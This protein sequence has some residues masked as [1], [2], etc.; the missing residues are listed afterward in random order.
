MVQEELPLGSETRQEVL[1]RVRNLLA[2][3]LLGAT[4]DEALLREVVKC[5]FCKT[6]MLASEAREDHNLPSERLAA[7]YR[8]TFHAIRQ[9][10]AGIFGEDEEVLL[11]PDT[12]AVVDLQLERMDLLRS[13]DD[14]LGDV[15]EAFI[16]VALRGQEGQFFTPLAA[17]RLLVDLVEPA[18][19]ERVI[20][21]ACGTGGFLSAV[22]WRWL[23]EGASSGQI[24]ASLYGIDKDSFLVD[25]ARL[26]VALAADTT[27]NI[28]CAD[29]LAWANQ[30]GLPF[31]D[32]LGSFDVVLTNPPFGKHIVAASGQVLG[33]FQLGRKWVRRQGIGYE[34]TN[35]IQKQVPPQVLF[36]ERCLTLLRPG[37]RAGVVVPES[38]ISTK[39]Y[40]YVVEFLLRHA[41]VIAVVGMPDALFKTSGKGGTHT[42]T[43]LLV[44]EKKADGQPTQGIKIFMAEARWCGHDSRG[45]SIPKDDLPRIGELYGEH[46]K[47]GISTERPMGFTVNVEQV[48]ASG[49]LAPRFYDPDLDAELARLRTTHDLVPMSQLID[50]RSIAIST[51]DEIGKLS[52]GTGDIPFVRT[53]DIS[54]WEIKVDPKHCVSRELFEQ[55]RQKQDVREHDILMVKDGTY[56][57]GTCAILTMYDQDILYQSH[58][59]KIRVLPGSP[60]DPFLL[61]VLL[62]SPVVQRQIR[63]KTFTQDIIDSLGSRIRDI[64][65]P[66]PRDEAHRQRVSAMVRRVIEERVEARELAR[67]A[68]AEVVQDSSLA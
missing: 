30:Q 42:K 12:L 53:S 48:Q 10:L 66:I 15:Y 16:G 59:Y 29:S 6:H 34:P 65:L 7:R 1:G 3:R 44:F 37:G 25:L 14:P 51:G 22:A 4:R 45:K 13:G 39:T 19:G 32:L 47:N 57:I 31:A 58:L 18:P 33:T 64:V 9:D 56:L 49:V 8:E 11:D 20:D 21:P 50:E 41:D 61:L 68:C 36:L 54:N 23:S 52:Y 27:P 46:R 60:L 28:A 63:T 35:E 38:M 2:G 17:V 40:R 5:V 43:C 55:L 26:H 62:S 67:R 24:A